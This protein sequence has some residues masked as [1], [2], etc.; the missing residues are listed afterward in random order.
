MDIFRQGLESLVAGPQ[1]KMANI[2]S[3]ITGSVLSSGASKSADL[4]GI[5]ILGILFSEIMRPEPPLDSPLIRVLRQRQEPDYSAA[6][7]I[8]VNNTRRTL[9]IVAQ[10]Q[11]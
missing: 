11:N 6:M 7:G 10:F 8:M 9:E 4:G 5:R 3:G 1:P 2:L